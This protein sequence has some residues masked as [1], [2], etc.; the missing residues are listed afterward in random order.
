MMTQVDEI[1]KDKHISMIFVEFLEAVVRVANKAEI[2]HCIIDE[3]T[4]GVDEVAP[5]MR[6][7]Y[8]SRD[9]VI[10]L[11]AFILFLIAGNLSLSAYTKYVNN[12]EEYRSL[13][14]YA[15]DLDIGNLNLNIKR[16]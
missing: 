14:L 5:E 3:F 1:D 9:I 12:L 13:G 11:E 10:K 7:S 4:W 6:E 8:A 16:S 2:P 15:N